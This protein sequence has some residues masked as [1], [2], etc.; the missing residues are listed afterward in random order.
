MTQRQRTMASP[1]MEACDK[2]PLQLSAESDTLAPHT[3]SPDIFNA[4]KCKCSL[5]DKLL[6]RFLEHCEGDA[7]PH[8]SPQASLLIPEA[9]Y[10]LRSFRG[11]WGNLQHAWR[12]LL[13]M[14]GWVF[15]PQNRQDWLLCPSEQSVF[16]RDTAAL[17]PQS[18]VGLLYQTR[19]RGRCDSRR[20][21]LAATSLD[22]IG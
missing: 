14:P 6:S 16:L 7:W 15:V 12:S 19:G 3:V 18:R 1:F 13:V 21:T 2:R 20:S 22:G 4:S 9:W 17:H 11:H 8:P 10:L 5:G